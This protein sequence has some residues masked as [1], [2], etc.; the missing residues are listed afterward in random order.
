MKRFI[1]SGLIILWSSLLEAGSFQAPSI[2]AR[3]TGMGG[4][5]V[6]A[7]D[8]PLAIYWNPAGLNRLR[9]IASWQSR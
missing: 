1:L 2:G 7:V 5:Y 9:A 4:A 3:A 8:D 6:A